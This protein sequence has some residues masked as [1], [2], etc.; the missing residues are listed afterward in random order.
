MTVLRQGSAAEAGMRTETVELILERAGEWAE[1]DNTVGLVLLLAR[2]G[3]VCLHEAWGRTTTESYG[4]PCTTDSYFCFASNS[5]PIA[6]TAAMQLVEQGLLSL[7]RPV[8]FYIPEFTAPGTDGILVQQLLTH[9]TGYDIERT[10]AQVADC[11]ASGIELPPCP[12]DEHPELHKL[13]QGIYRTSPAAKPASEMFY[14]NENFTLLGEIIRR[15]AG[16]PYPEYLQRNVFDPLGM[17]DSQ[18]GLT[19]DVAAGLVWDF[20]KPFF[21]GM[22]SGDDLRDSMRIPNAAGAVFGT[23]MDYAMFAQMLLTKGRHGEHRI[24]HP[25]SVAQMTRNQIPGVGTDF[26]GDFTVEAGWGL[27]INILI[28]ERWPWSDG[29]LPANGCYTH[30]GGGGMSFWVDPGLDLI[31]VYACFCPEI[32]PLTHEQR[33]DF[34]LFQNMA[35]AAV[36]GIVT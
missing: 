32:N 29:S 21:E 11:L 13:L 19:D 8:R 10:P 3:V 2:H 33:W 18:V 23:A 6:A 25:A 34:D 24:L 1:Q 17:T 30:G 35:T 20:S 14:A 26:L 27:G 31:G 5:K 4:Q 36:Q 9:T 15:V 7:T 22:P 28:Q 16:V 12:P